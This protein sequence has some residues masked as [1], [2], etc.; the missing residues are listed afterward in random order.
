MSSHADLV[1]RFNAGKT[2]GTASHMFIDGDTLYSYGYHFPLCHHLH[3]GFLMNGDKYSTTTSGHQRACSRIATIII[4]FS[5]LVSANIRPRDIRLI[6]KS[7][8]RYDNLEYINDKGEKVTIQER[9]PESCVFEYQGNYYLSSMDHNNYFIAQLPGPVNDTKKA[10]EMLKPV[11]GIEGI[12]YLR[13]GEW[14]F[15][16][17]EDKPVKIFKSSMDRFRLPNRNNILHH[18]P[19][20]YGYSK[21]GELLVRGTIRHSQGDHPM[22]RLGKQWYLAHESNHIN[23]WGA[24]GRID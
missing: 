23:S 2:K 6:S 12:D 11:N 1:E 21:T 20:E 5:A 24:S 17:V 4:P 16:P 19:T 3:W 13:Q 15:V 7:N 10:F 14:F 22:L 18:Y 8:A 9:R